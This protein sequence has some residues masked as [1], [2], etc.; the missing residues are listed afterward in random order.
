MPSVT[1]L[2][3]RQKTKMPVLAGP[4][5]FTIA[6]STVCA[7]PSPPPA[8]LAPVAVE[9]THTAVLLA[10]EDLEYAGAPPIEYELQSRGTL[11]NNM[12]WTPVFPSWYPKVKGKPVN[13]A[14]R[15]PG[16]GLRYR[17]RAFNHGGWG[18]YSYPSET[19][20]TIPW[21]PNAVPSM[22]GR[23]MSALER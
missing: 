15:V 3:L 13:I 6:S 10:W 17:V 19:I 20:T 9:V 14:H 2:T 5:V 18:E 22:A 4:D 11:R 12:R 23:V 7:A 16:L 8:P 1:T 21:L